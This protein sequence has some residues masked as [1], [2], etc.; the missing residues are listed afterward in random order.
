[1]AAREDAY[2][3][4]QGVSHWAN[5][6]WAP[7]DACPFS[8]YAQGVWANGPHD[9]WLND[10]CHFDGVGWKVAGWNTIPVK[11]LGGRE[12]NSGG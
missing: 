9:V 8:A 1:V 4:N 11:L 5:G 3:V 2:L 7:I 10:G 6:R 12:G